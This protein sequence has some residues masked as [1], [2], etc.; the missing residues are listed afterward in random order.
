MIL[1]YLEQTVVLIKSADV[2]KLQAR[3]SEG[4]GLGSECARPVWV[5]RKRGS[6]DVQR[7]RLHCLIENHEPPYAALRKLKRSGAEQVSGGNVRATTGD[8]AADG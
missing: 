2:V 6:P 4:R 7:G 3:T 5:D 1:T 8:A